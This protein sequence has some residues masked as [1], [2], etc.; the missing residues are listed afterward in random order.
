MNLTTLWRR[1][2]DQDLGAVTLES[3]ISCSLHFAL[4]FGV[5]EASLGVYA[6]HYIAEAAREGTRYASVRGSSCAGSNSAC[7]A[8]ASDIQTYVKG[9][10]YPGI[11]PAAITVTTTWSA[12]ASGTTCSPSS[13]CNNPG[14]L[15]RVEVQYQFPFSVP[16][17]PATIWA[18]KSS[19]AMVI[20]Q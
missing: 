7:P 9:L 8:Q 20:S 12:F 16:L 15:V 1:F 17:L 11:S 4:L 19:S 5:M 18:V 14:D 13:S 10:A 3:A 2:A 6:F